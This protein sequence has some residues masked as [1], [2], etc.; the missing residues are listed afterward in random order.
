M[1]Q[2]VPDIPLYTLTSHQYQTRSEDVGL[3]VDILAIQAR[4]A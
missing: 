1:Q 2:Q 3:V 4:C